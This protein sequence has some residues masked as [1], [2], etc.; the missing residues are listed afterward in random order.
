MT[1]ANVTRS[2]GVPIAG[3]GLIAGGGTPDNED[4]REHA[5]AAAAA[6]STYFDGALVSVR[7]NSQGGSGGAWL[8]TNDHDAVGR[9]AEIGIIAWINPETNER[10]FTVRLA[11]IATGTTEHFVASVDTLPEALAL[12]AHEAPVTLDELKARIQAASDKYREEHLRMGLVARQSDGSAHVV[13]ADTSEQ[14]KALLVSVQRSRAKNNL[15]FNTW[16]QEALYEIK[17]LQVSSRRTGLVSHIRTPWKS[18]L[19]VETNVVYVI[20]PDGKSAE[21]LGA[22][23]SGRR[24]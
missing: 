18:A 14:G 17:D 22:A 11:P 20:A 23:F 13:F 4:Y 24:R 1:I 10:G 16:H 7:F 19:D 2:P 15:V 6:L 3:T 9:N 21:S 12:V 8:V 5:D